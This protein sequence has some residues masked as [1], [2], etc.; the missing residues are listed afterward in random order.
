MPRAHGSTYLSEE[1][2]LRR[3]DPEAEKPSET[4]FI[5]LTA[6]AKRDDAK[7]PP[8]NDKNSAEKSASPKKSNKPI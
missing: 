5:T 7:L 4:K 8:I 1:E 2:I 3:L 6:G